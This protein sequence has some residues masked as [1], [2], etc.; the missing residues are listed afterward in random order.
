MHICFITNEF[1]KPG[2]SHGG[3]GTFVATLGKA[4]V[5]RGV[6][7]SVIGKNQE[8]KE[9]RGLIDGIYVWRLVPKSVKGLQWYFNSKAIS[10]AI[11]LRHK[12]QPIDI[13]ETPELGLA[14]LSKIKGVKYIIRMHGGHHFF[15][16]AEERSKQ[17][18]H[19]FEEKRSFGKADAVLAVSNYVKDTTRTLV[20]LG[21][22][23]ITVIYNPI[24]VFK[25]EHNY[26]FDVN[27][28]SIFFAG[29]LVEKKGVRQLVQALEFLIPHFPKVHLYIAG[30]DAM[31]P[32]TRTP[33]R[34]ILE[35]AITDK[36]SKY[37][38]FLGVLPNNEMPKYIS[39]AAVCCY[40]SHMEAMPL[41]W[42]EVLA[43]GKIFVGSTTGPGPEAVR[44]M[45]TGLLAN[46]FNPKDIAEKIAWVFNHEAEAKTLGKV[47]REDV[48]K[49]FNV[50]V[51]VNENIEFYTTLCHSN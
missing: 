27:P 32:G 2:F 18:K 9:E 51:I 37:I 31:V 36:L 40:P 41:A 7:V 38:T 34:P 14:F 20:N 35:A 23:P 44:H 13:V 4:L 33:Y 10:N 42:L 25:F 3:V 49:R 22:I 8:S 29:S 1:P 47:A 19:V 24:D 50:D 48:L 12:Q 30:R 46:P 45:E 15:A 26:E 17:W 39:E 16:K 6:Q 21:D 28:Y 11:A 5:T 43:S